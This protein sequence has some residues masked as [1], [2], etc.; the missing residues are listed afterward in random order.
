MPEEI[1]LAKT[2]PL[3]ETHQDDILIEAHDDLDDTGFDAKKLGST[4]RVAR[5]HDVQKWPVTRI[6]CAPSTARDMKHSSDDP[7]WRISA[8]D[9]Q[10]R[11]RDTLVVDVQVT[12]LIV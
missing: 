6:P 5:G 10:Q 3:H 7:S 1:G 2:R 8:V 12:T 9:S 4:W 11:G